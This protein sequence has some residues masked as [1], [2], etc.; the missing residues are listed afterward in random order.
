MAR[1]NVDEMTQCHNVR[2]N[3][4]LLDVNSCWPIK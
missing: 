3:V 1:T 4:I 2:V